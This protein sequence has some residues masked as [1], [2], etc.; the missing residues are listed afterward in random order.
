MDRIDVR[1]VC[2]CNKWLLSKKVLL[3]LS[4]KVIVRSFEK[5]CISN[6]IMDGA[7]DDVNF[8]EEADNYELYTDNIHPDIPMR[9]SNY[10]KK[11][12][13]F[14]YK[15]NFYSIFKN[16]QGFFFVYIYH[17]FNFEYQNW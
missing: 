10:K 1:W 8:E 6:A 5:C 16:L 7:E 13:L 9:K 14:Y 12:D 3:K 11:I 4:Q 2:I 15:K 17:Y